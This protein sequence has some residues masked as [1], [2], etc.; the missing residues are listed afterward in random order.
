MEIEEVKKIK[1]YDE[2]TVNEFVRGLVKAR[3]DIAKANEELDIRAE[4]V[5]L[6]EEELE[7]EISEEEIIKSKEELKNIKKDKEKTD[8]TLKKWEK[9]KERIKAKL[10]SKKQENEAKISENQQKIQDLENEIK[11]NEEKMQ[12]LDQE[13]EEYTELEKA[14]REISK[15]IS[16]VRG[17]I[18]RYEKKINNL[19]EMIGNLEEEN[20]LEGL[21][22]PRTIDRVVTR[23]GKSTRKIDRTEVIENEASIQENIQMEENEEIASLED[24]IRKSAAKMKE[25]RDSGNFEQEAAEHAYYNSLISK[26]NDLKTERPTEIVKEEKKE[27]QQTVENVKVENVDQQEQPKIEEE[28]Q[29][30]GDKKTE[31][32]Q[33]KK[34]TETIKTGATQI[35]KTATPV[36]NVQVKRPTQTVRPEIAQVEQQT[37][38][39]KTETAQEK[40]P[41]ETVKTETEKAETKSEIKWNS[42]LTQEQ[43]EELIAE[44]IEPGDNEYNLYLWN[45]GINPF[46][47]LMKQKQEATKSVADSVLEKYKNDGFGKNAFGWYFNPWTDEYDKDY[48][49]HN[50]PEYNEKLK[51]EKDEKIDKIE[52]NK[53]EEEPKK[54][55]ILERIKNAARKFIDTIKRYIDNFNNKRL[56]EPKTEQERKEYVEK[57]DKILGETVSTD[58]I[59]DAQSRAAMSQRDNFAARVHISEELKRQI[60]ETKEN[61]AEPKE[62][63]SEEAER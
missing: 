51:E 27:E 9:E 36:K 34:S 47:G 29:L 12:E 23:P 21:K 6:K 62:V 50:D 41:A 44:G 33:V 14:N 37:Q 46:E 49:P 16:R 26:M 22:P 10:D 25:Y 11:A 8:K 40:K 2:Y 32:I 17:S 24:E 3:S 53:T 55:S 42:K 59:F 39:T 38:I 54:V 30:T 35:R 31:A 20:V 43:I 60:N 63:E 28:K 56:P 48:D 1:R 58:R 45:H 61:V 5:S 4:N 19:I 7:V 57:A 15:K 13:S 18:T 52:K